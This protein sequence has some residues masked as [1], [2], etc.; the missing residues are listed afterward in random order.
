MRSI[1][2][3]KQSMRF[4]VLFDLAVTFIKATPRR[5]ELNEWLTPVD[6]DGHG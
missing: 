6:R 5:A 3:A 1:Q 4:R 2:L